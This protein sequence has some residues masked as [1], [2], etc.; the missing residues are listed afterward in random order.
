MKRRNFYIIMTLALVALIILGVGLRRGRSSVETAKAQATTQ[1]ATA[2][3]ENINIVSAPGRVEPISEEIEVG[4]EIGGK[5][6]EVRVEEGDPVARGQI[7]AVLENAAY[8]AQVRSAEADIRNAEAQRESAEARLTGAEAELR[9]VVNGARTEER[10]EARASLLQAEATARNARVEL[11]RRRELYAHGVIA[12]EERDRAARDAEVAMARVEEL[13][14]R[15]AFVSAAAREEDSARAESNV[16]LARAQIRE[17]FARAQGARARRDEASAT[18][19]KTYVRAPISGVVLRR[20][21]NAG[22]SYSLE[23]QDTA[24][25]SIFTL[26]DTSTLRVR[27]EVDERDVGSVRTGQPAYMTADTYPDRKF[28]GRVVRVGQVMGRKNVRT[29]EPTERVDTKILEVL[30]ELDQGQHLPPGLRVD[31]FITV[32]VEQSKESKQ[33]DRSPEA[34]M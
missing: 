27:V 19:E 11:D 20:R 24:R 25:A 23:T 15:S 21:L 29:E 28:T 3:R 30:V 31:A 8:A 6:H 13:R 12:R 34:G 5:I 16:T 17:V 22:E 1:R 18:L 4:A 9:R 32:G 7:L 33:P 14:Q 10:G 2:P 26:A